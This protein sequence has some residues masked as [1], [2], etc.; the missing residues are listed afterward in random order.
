MARRKESLVDVVAFFPWYVGLLLALTVYLA[1]RHGAPWYFISNQF[2]APMGQAI[3]NFARLFTL[4]FIAGSAF[5]LTKSISNRRLFKQQKD[6]D[7]IRAL[8]W[9]E[10]E[11][12]IGE[13]FRRQGYSIAETDPG[14]DGGVDLILRKEGKRYYV[15]CKHWKARQIGVNVVRELMV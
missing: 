5:S 8:S 1:A 7:S 13:A 10:F 4:P 9:R 12:L 3:A 14:A 15:Q 6:L 11:R 2:G